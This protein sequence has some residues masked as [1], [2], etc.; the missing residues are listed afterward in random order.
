MLPE[1]DSFVPGAYYEPI[2]TLGLTLRPPL[3][4]QY[5]PLASG[6]VSSVRGSA[7]STGGYG[8]MITINHGNGYESRYGR[9]S[10]A[11]GKERY[12][13]RKQH[14]VWRNRLVGAVGQCVRSTFD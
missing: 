11:G 3:E 8:L 10:G 9:L 4:R 2:R 14:R 13:G 1:V 6:K 7:S 5:L 12:R